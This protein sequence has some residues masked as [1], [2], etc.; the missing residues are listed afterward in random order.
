MAARKNLD[1]AKVLAYYQR[2]GNAQETARHFGVARSA[3]MHHIESAGI[4]KPLQGG[5]AG[6]SC[7]SRR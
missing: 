3:I 6:A 2:C 1:K 4:I 7:P 5:T